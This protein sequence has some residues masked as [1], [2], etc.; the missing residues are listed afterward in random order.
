MLNFYKEEILRKRAGAALWPAA[1]RPAHGSSIER[2]SKMKQPSTVWPLVPISAT[3]PLQRCRPCVE[4]RCAVPAHASGGS[5]HF[6]PHVAGRTLPV[7]MI[8]MSWRPPSGCTD[9]AGC[10]HGRAACGRALGCQNR[11]TVVGLGPLWCPRPAVEE[12]ERDEDYPPARKCTGRRVF[13]G[14]NRG[15]GG[16]FLGLATAPM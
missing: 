7:V 3:C 2:P 10:P 12:H 8:W 11:L 9:V 16:G 4:K 5:V 14:L 13:C 15:A 1:R 6:R